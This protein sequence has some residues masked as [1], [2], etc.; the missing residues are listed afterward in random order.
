MFM[1]C[2]HT[3]LHICSYNN[4]LSTKHKDS[5][6][7]NGQDAANIINMAYGKISIL[8][9]Q[10]IMLGSLESACIKP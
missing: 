7:S 5:W 10:N 8:G 2:F 9:Y 6:K 1:I 4:S 3:Y